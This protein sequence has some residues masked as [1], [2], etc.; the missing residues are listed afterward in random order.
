MQ[1]IQQIFSVSI[2]ALLLN[3]FMSSCESIT[4]AISPNPSCKVSTTS[5]GYN[6]P[7]PTTGSSGITTTTNTY[8][9][10][11]LKTSISTIS[12]SNTGSPTSTYTATSTYNYD[13]NGYLQS[14]SYITTPVIGQITASSLNSV[15]TYINNKISSIVQTNNLNNTVRHT[16]NYT[17]DSQG[18][19]STI[20][21]V[22]SNYTETNTYSNNILTGITRVSL[23][24]SILKTY[25]VT[26]GRKT[27]ETGGAATAPYFVYI[28]NAQGYLSELQN[29]SSA[30]TMS[31]RT[32][33]EYVNAKEAKVT[34]L[35]FP[36]II[37]TITGELM[38]SKSTTYN[39]SNIKTNEM[40]TTYTLTPTGYVASSDATQTF[41]NT[42]GS[43]NGS[44]STINL[45][46]TYQ[47]CN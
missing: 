41:F 10:E 9:G 37:S 7:S 14:L 5:Y 32:T 38:T 6:F 30:S 17:Y 12:S 45:T 46:Y 47:D 24:G 23:N 15:Y 16:I 11:L 39:A 22:N 44:P 42:N 28:Y 43:V 33:Y 2:T 25:T 1:K 19:V 4:P 40:L 31:S 20:T 35:G 13:A 8:Q 26:N 36:V 29:W 18:N 34:L 27:R 21:T 3:W